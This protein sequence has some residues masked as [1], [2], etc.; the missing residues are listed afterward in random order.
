MSF[1]VSEF[2]QAPANQLSPDR[3]SGHS[4]LPYFTVVTNS[5]N[6]WRVSPVGIEV[7][8]SFGLDRVRA[9]VRWPEHRGGC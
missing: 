5:E 4:Q 6:C 2:C 7:E 3:K 9:A 1:Y 8:S